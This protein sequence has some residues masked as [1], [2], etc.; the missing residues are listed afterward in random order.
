MSDYK[1][2][3]A[4]IAEDDVPQLTEV[5]TRTFDDDARKHLGKDKGGPPGYD[6][7]EFF[8]EW[9]F[10]YEQTVGYKAV[11]DGRIVGAVIVWIIDTGNNYLGTIFVDPQYQDQGV[12]SQIWAHIERTYPDTKSW[13][14]ETPSV[15]V[16]NHHFYEKCGFRKID[17]KP[18]EDDMPCESWVFRKEVV[19]SDGVEG[20][21]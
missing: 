19:C 14:L 5:M 12:G 6:N 15:A 1:L 3:I 11:I 17:V 2:T 9:L 21:D 16:K 4:G 10:G 20:G 18:A 7:G 13:Q 8:R